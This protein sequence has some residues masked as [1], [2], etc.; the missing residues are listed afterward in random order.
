[1]F[2]GACGARLAWWQAATASCARDDD[3]T[4]AAVLREAG[5]VQLLVGL[6]SSNDH[7]LQ[8]AA[9]GA[10]ANIRKWHLL[11]SEQP[12]GVSRTILRALAAQRVEE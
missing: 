4:N 5:G 8:Q 3:A 6:M 1:V 12:K 11:F 9:A 7:E 2:L 10:I